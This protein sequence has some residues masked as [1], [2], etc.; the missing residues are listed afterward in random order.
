[1]KGEVFSYSRPKDGLINENLDFDT[2]KQ[3]DQFDIK[4]FKKDTDQ[5][6][7]QVNLKDEIEEL[8]RQRIADDTYD[9]V[10]PKEK[11]VNKLKSRLSD[12]EFR[13]L[14]AKSNNSLTEDIMELK[15]TNI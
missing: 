15:N 10:R 8:T 1:M 12:E 14:F 7:D 4:H 9:D 5:V 6:Q 2:I 3:L 13:K 11:T